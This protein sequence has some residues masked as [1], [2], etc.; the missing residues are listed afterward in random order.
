MYIAFKWLTALAVILWLA[1]C[2]VDIYL[3]ECKKKITLDT[4]VKPY[5]VFAKYTNG[6]IPIERNFKTK[7]KA[8]WKYMKQNHRQQN[9]AF[10][11]YIT[12]LAGAFAVSIFHKKTEIIKYTQNHITK[13]NI[14]KGIKW[15]NMTTSAIHLK[16]TAVFASVATLNYLKFLW[17]SARHLAA[18]AFNKPGEAQNINSTLLKRVKEIGQDRKTLGQLLLAAI[19]DNKN[20]R[21]RCQSETTAKNRLMQYIEETQKLIKENRTRYV[22]FQQLYSVTHK[23]NVFLR[24]RIKK[25][26]SEK[27]DAEKNLMTLIN[28]VYRSQ[29]TN[30]KAY[31]ARFIVHTKKNLLNKDVNAE[32]R[33]FLQK[34]NEPT[35]VAS[36][37]VGDQLGNIMLSGT[38]SLPE[39]SL[40]VTDL[41]HDDINLVRL[42][43]DAPK[44]RGL[45]GECVW[46]VKDKN[47]IIEKLYEYDYETDYDNGDTIRR[48][49]EYS[50]YHDKDWLLDQTNVIPK[51]PDCP[52]LSA[53]AVR[54]RLDV[55]PLT[56]MG[57]LTRSK[58]F[59]S[60]LE[61]S[62][63]CV[64]SK[65]SASPLS[66]G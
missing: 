53:S 43:S 31:C 66:C 42:V 21:L 8:N 2:C 13:T 60:F 54:I 55:K 57:F 37:G 27:E 29:N 63:G 10:L 65:T 5:Y 6:S 11:H 47:G 46:T 17:G 24:S 25:L 62:P 9:I 51:L 59:K 1:L 16:E 32:I 38:S 52:S 4:S 23:E 18:V 45:P 48:I 49:R 19:N 12:F 7:D 35:S 36:R 14:L 22:N 39:C 15:V 56:N 20:I 30:L 64:P 33:K 28:E 61:N 50:V 3:K 58:Q 44:L 26:V 40:R 34:S 41:F